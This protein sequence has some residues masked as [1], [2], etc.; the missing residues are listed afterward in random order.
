MTVSSTGIDAVLQ[1]QPPAFTPEQACEIGRGTFGIE[2][3]GARNL[4]SERDQAFMLTGPSGSGIAVLK[5][6]NPA[7][8][9]AMLDMEAL[10]ALHASRCDPGLAIAL[11]RSEAGTRITFGATARDLAACRVRWMHGGAGHWVRAYDVLPGR[12]TAGSAH[13]AGLRA[14]RAG[15]K[16]PRGWAS[17]CAASSTRVRSA[18]CRGTSSMRRASGR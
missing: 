6:S 3:S 10:A 17:R 2:A 13:A 16:R 5:V 1:A 9:P 4:G 15:V 12:V 18:A 11:P 14:D 8:D 7:E